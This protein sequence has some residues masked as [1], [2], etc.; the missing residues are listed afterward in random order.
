MHVYLNLIYTFGSAAAMSEMRKAPLKRTQLNNDWPNIS[1]D[2]K[3]FECEIEFKKLLESKNIDQLFKPAQLNFLDDYKFQMLLAHILDSLDMLPLRPDLAFDNLWK[4]IDSIAL[5]KQLS[6]GNQNISRFD[7][8]IDELSK[9]DENFSIFNIYLQYLPLQT[10][11]YIAKRLIQEYGKRDPKGN[12]NNLS[13]RANSLLGAEAV[14]AFIEKYP[15][16]ENGKPNATDTFQAGKCLKI[17]F[18]TRKIILGDNDKEYTFE[19]KNLSIFL[20]KTILPMYRNERFHGAVFPSFRSSKATISSY[21][22][23]YYLFHIVYALSLEIIVNTYQVISIDDAIG[24]MEINA[25][26][27]N[28]VF[29]D[30]Y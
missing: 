30:K 17:L 15:R 12:L 25:N 22:H 21:A 1:P 14:Q 7:F 2:Q 23:A 19:S 28:T 24:A 29:E 26:L 16:Q 13:K 8:I 11:E 18:S 4:K 10:C 6:N 3:Y 27:F 9:N 20:I 5:K